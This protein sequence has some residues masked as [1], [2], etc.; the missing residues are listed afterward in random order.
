MLSKTQEIVSLKLEMIELDFHLGFPNQLY[1]YL[2]PC[3]LIAE[4]R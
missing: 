3:L 4:A 2:L 1:A